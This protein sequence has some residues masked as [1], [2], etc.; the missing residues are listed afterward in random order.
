MKGL[1]LLT[2]IV[3]FAVNLP[4]AIWGQNYLASLNSETKKDDAIFL[5]LEITGIVNL[6]QSAPDGTVHK[7]TLPKADCKI[8]MK[9]DKDTENAVGVKVVTF[10][11]DEFFYESNFIE[12][13]VIIR[14][15]DIE[16]DS[17]AMITCDRK[18]F[19][20]LVFEKNNNEIKYRYD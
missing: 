17:D 14:A 1:A 10:P 15:P 18:N 3:L 5:S 7:M 6:L 12:T 8:I 19:R 9:L 11:K 20:K 16:E 13:D 4:I 2:V